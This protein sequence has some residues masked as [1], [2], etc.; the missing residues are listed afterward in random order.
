MGGKKKTR[1]DYAGSET[2]ASEKPD[3]TKKNETNS[4]E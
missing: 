3:A 4:S 2:L 1:A